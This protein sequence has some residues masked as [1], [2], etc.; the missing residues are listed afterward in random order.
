MRITQA[1]MRYRPVTIV[2]EDEDDFDQL[3][4][5]LRQVAGN[6]INHTPQVIDAAKKLH[7]E[8]FA[9]VEEN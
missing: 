2:L 3:M 7:R 9:L 5:V 6:C 4:A 1:P 8:L